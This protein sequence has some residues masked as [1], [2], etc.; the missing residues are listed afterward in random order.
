MSSTNPY[1]TFPSKIIKIKKET[2]ID[3]T[4]RVLSNFKPH[5]SKFFEISLPGYGEAPISVND[6]LDEWLDFT[7]RKVEQLTTA[8]HNLKEGDFLYIRGPYANGFSKDSFL[9]KHLV[10]IA[11]GSDVAPVR[12]LINYYLKWERTHSCYYKWSRIIHR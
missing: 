4:F 1:N 12:G 9:N 5:Y 2:P 8:I 10:I 3:F 6:F 7:I 11:E